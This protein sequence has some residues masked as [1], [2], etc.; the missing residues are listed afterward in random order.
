MACCLL[1][2]QSIPQDV[3]ENAIHQALLLGY[4]SGDPVD[5]STFEALIEAVTLNPSFQIPFSATPMMS[6]LGSWVC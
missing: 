4:L 2:S 1:D 5:E 6:H 3:T